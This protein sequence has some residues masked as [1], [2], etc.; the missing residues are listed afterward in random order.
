M[1]F[2]YRL[3]GL[4]DVWFWR[5]PSAEHFDGV[6]S[7]DCS[8]PLPINCVCGDGTIEPEP[9][10]LSLPKNQD[11][12]NPEWSGIDCLLILASGGSQTSGDDS[13]TWSDSSTTS[14][15]IMRLI[16]RLPGTN[17]ACLIRLNLLMLTGSL[18]AV[19]SSSRGRLSLR[20]WTASAG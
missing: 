17:V 16:K 18:M 15:S 6:A 9:D 12:S 8:A 4:V 20:C 5:E 14:N 7:S 2:Q 11:W 1:Q 19:W 3:A 13:I 10:A